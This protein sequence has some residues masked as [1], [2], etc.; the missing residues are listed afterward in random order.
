VSRRAAGLRDDTGLGKRLG[1][2]PLETIVAPTLVVSAR[3]DG[4]GTY[5]GAEYTASRIP[6][7]RFLGFERGGHLLVGHDEQVRGEVLRLITP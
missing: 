2:S 1:P 4:F 6:G 5:A 7:A 3:D